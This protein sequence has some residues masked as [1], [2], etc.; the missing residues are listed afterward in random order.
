MRN[1]SKSR[2]FTLIELL[3][4]IAIIAILAA[5][6][7]PVFAK[8]REKARQSSC[9]NNQ[10]QIAVAILMY[11]QDHDE[12]CPDH[13]DVWVQLGVD[14][15][16][17]MC[18]TKGKK[19][20]NAYVYAYGVSSVTLGEL[21]DPSGT[22]LTMDGQHAAT[23]SPVTYDNVAYTVD[24]LDA[25]HSNKFVCTFAD[26]H[27]DIMSIT[28][29][30]LPMRRNLVMQ[31]KADDFTGLSNGDEIT[32]WKDA[33]GKGN[34]MMC[35]SAAGTRP[36]YMV[37]VAKNGAMP[38]IRLRADVAGT[39]Y[40]QPASTLNPRTSIDNSWTFL[41]VH[42][43]IS[44]TPTGWADGAVLQNWTTPTGDW[45]SGGHLVLYYVSG[46]SAAPTVVANT[47]WGYK[48]SSSCYGTA[49]SGTF[50][51]GLFHM[52]GYEVNPTTYLGI[53]ERVFTDDQIVYTRTLSQEYGDYPFDR[54]AI[55]IRIEGSA[56]TYYQPMKGDLTEVLMFTP[57]ISDLERGLVY[58]YL[59]KKWGM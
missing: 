1:G 56:P 53:V 15:N 32:T 18:P 4:V 51:V 35:A 25:R 52:Y 30:K 13:A 44:S 24:D 43:P 22:L 11:A 49:T 42:A 58:G 12:T 54:Y 45:T 50:G 20:A 8:A 3:V 27:V 10:R 19:V 40:L 39:G 14:R 7:F 26:G 23:T 31:L 38:A 9:L 5:I 36:Q 17:L 16:I 6:L 41:A 21:S 28:P 37:G 34:H 59:K 55:G 48:T 46:L 47:M 29:D 33:S 57:G 2:G